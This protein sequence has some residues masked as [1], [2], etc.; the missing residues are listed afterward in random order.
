MSGRKLLVPTAYVWLTQIA[1]LKAS[2]LPRNPGSLRCLN[3]VLFQGL[4]VD[5]PVDGCCKTS[6]WVKVGAGPCLWNLS[7]RGARREGGSCVWVGIKRTDLFP[8]IA[9]HR[10]FVIKRVTTWSKW[11]QRSACIASVS[12]KQ[13]FDER[14]LRTLKS[15]A[16]KK[17]TLHNKISAI[18]AAS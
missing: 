10:H 9:D 3:T 13:F 5:S 15:G 16:E 2:F 17:K 6:V 14:D 1:D 11:S 7:G 4:R 8:D 12:S 18:I